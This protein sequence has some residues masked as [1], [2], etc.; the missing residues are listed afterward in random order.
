MKKQIF[1]NPATGK[2]Q[3]VPVINGIVLFS[4]GFD[5]AGKVVYQEFERKGIINL[6]GF[7]PDAKYFVR[8]PH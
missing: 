3:S 2:R 4:L 6:R 5:E 8:F 7:L 1:T